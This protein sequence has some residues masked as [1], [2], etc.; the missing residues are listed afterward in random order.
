MQS[1]QRFSWAA[2]GAIAIFAALL[3]LLAAIPE[4]RPED[5]HG[6]MYVL[7]LSLILLSISA[8][9]FLVG[10]WFKKSWPGKWFVLTLP[11]IAVAGF[12]AFSILGAIPPI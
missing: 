5:H 3:F 12:I 7:A 10:L 11:A 8:Y 1:I 6:G 4:P 2:S 9:F